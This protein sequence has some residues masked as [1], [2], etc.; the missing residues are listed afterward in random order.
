MGW[1]LPG[2]RDWMAV[3]WEHR[4]GLKASTP[5]GW[6]S[7]EA[8]DSVSERPSW[9]TEAALCHRSKPLSDAT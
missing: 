3:A 7:L 6:S 8:Q 9:V 4:E 1:T 5:R 2:N